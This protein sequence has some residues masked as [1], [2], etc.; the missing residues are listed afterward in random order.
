MSDSW[1]EYDT[2][3][4]NT[5]YDN[6]TSIKLEKHTLNIGIFHTQYMILVSL[7]KLRGLVSFSLHFDFPTSA[8]RS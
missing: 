6:Y 8:S 7:E 1:A 5:E 4:P 2:V 3:L